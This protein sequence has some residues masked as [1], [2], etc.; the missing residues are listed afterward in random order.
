MC[1]YSDQFPHK[2]P[3]KI[4]NVNGYSVKVKQVK[5]ALHIEVIFN[6]YC[7]SN[8]ININLKVAF[9]LIQRHFTI[10]KRY[11]GRPQ[12]LLQDMFQQINRD[13]PL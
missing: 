8:V 3:R 7:R 2:P 9:F 5:K 10:Y 1:Y 11:K 6:L 13:V 4:V 12:H